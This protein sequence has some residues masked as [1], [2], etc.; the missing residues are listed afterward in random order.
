MT[1]TQNHG[2][3]MSSDRVT[4]SAGSTHSRRF[5][6]SLAATTTHYDTTHLQ[7]QRHQTRP[8]NKTYAK[9]NALHDVNNHSSCQDPLPT[10]FA[11]MC[12]TK[13]ERSVSMQ[14]HASCEIL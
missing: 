13:C 6:T 1:L 8:T 3:L 10:L 7:S 12:L 4:R 9:L 14:V 2:C 11:M 5:T